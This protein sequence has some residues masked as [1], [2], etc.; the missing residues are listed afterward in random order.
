MKL[1]TRLL[2]SLLGLVSFL[3]LIGFLHGAEDSDSR[4]ASCNRGRSRLAR[5][6]LREE[7]YPHVRKLN[8]QLPL[9]CPFSQERDMFLDNEQHKKE[10]RFNNWKCLYC[11]KIFKS[12][13]YLENHYVNRH[14]ETIKQDG[15]CLA[16]YCDM[17]ECDMQ[18]TLKSPDGMFKTTTYRCDAKRMQ[19][20]R[21]RCHSVLD[22]C[23]PPHSSDAANRLHHEFEKL[24]CDHLSCEASPDGL[25]EVARRPHALLSQS[26]ARNEYHSK[27]TK[28]SPWKK[29][30]IVFGVLFAIILFIFYLGVCLYQKDMAILEDLRKLSSNRFS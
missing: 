9:N 27:K 30:A 21:H 1:K 13:A 19:K 4:H 22:K 3:A 12:E 7:F 14:P 25:G 16:D 2:R 28:N 5:D 8:F 24:Y 20:R 11:N 6:I 23:F 26:K 18:D 15:F 29:L 10:V 17:L